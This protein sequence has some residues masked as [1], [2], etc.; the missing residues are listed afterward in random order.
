MSEVQYQEILKKL[1]AIG[2]LLLAIAEKQGADSNKVIQAE[3][4]LR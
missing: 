3:M 1:E 2:L 4:K